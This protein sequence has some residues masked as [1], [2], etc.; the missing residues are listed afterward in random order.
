MI[1]RKRW[2]ACVF[3]G[4][5]VAGSVAYADVTLELRPSSDTVAN[6]GPVD[7]GVYAV[8]SGSGD[9]DV[10]RIRVVFTWDSDYLQLTGHQDGDYTW[11]Y[12]G[13]PTD[14]GPAGDEINLPQSGGVPD[15]DGDA[16]YFAFSDSGGDPPVA[17]TEGLHVTTL[18]FQS[19]DATPGT[20]VTIQSLI[21]STD[22]YI[23]TA[24]YGGD[25]IT[26]TIGS[27]STWSITC[28]TGNPVTSC[29]DGNLCTDDYC[30]SETS[31]THTPVSE[32][33]PCGDTG[34]GDCDDA[35]SCDASGN[36]LPNYWSPGTE[37]GNQ[38][39]SD[40]DHPNTCDVAGVCQPN[41]EPVGEACGNQD[42]SDCD[43]PDTCDGAGVC[44][45][46]YESL[47]GECG[48][49]DQTDCTDPDR[50]DGAGACD[51]V[52]ATNGFPCTDDENECTDDV[53]ETGEC[54]HPFLSVETPCGDDT[55]DA[56]TAPDW[57]D[58]I[59]TCLPRDLWD[60]YVW[61]D[62]YCLDVGGLA[63]CVEC[64]E[65][66][67]CDDENECTQDF[68]SGAHVCMNS[69]DGPQNG[70]PCTP[71]GVYC[72]GVDVCVDGDC[73]SPNIPPC[74][75][76]NPCTDAV[77]TEEPQDC[78]N[79]PNDS[80]DCDD[81][82]FC[83]NGSEYCQDGVC[84]SPG[85]PSCDDDNECTAD[86]CDDDPEIDDCVHENLPNMT[87]C[88]DG[89]PCTF[90]DYCL[91]GTCRSGSPPVGSGKVNL[92]WFPSAPTAILDEPFEI[93]LYARST[94]G[95][96]V[97]LVTIN[98]VLEWNPQKVEL[99]GINNNGPYA[100]FSTFFPCDSPQ[101]SL[102]T[103][104]FP[105][106]PDYEC[107]D[108]YPACCGGSCE[109]EY[110]DFP[111]NDGDALFSVY[112][113]L[114]APAQATP[115]P[116]LLITSF[117][118][119]ALET[120]PGTTLSLTLCKGDS[121]TVT[122]INGGNPPELVHGVLGSANI[123]VVT[124]VDDE[125]CDDGLF[126]NG[127]ERCVGETCVDA[128][129][130]ACDD[131][132]DCTEDYCDEGNDTCTN[133]PLDY[134]C[135][136][137][138]FCDGEEY[139]DAAHGCRNGVPPNCDDPDPCTEDYCD[140]DLDQC[141]NEEI[142]W[143][144]PCENDS[145]CED[146]IPCT[147]N[148]CDPFFEVCVY[149]RN[150]DFCID[151]GLYCNGEEICNPSDPDAD[152]DGC[153]HGPPPCAPED[154]DEINDTCPCAVPL[155]E[156]LGPRYIAITPQVDEGTRCAF[157]VT[158]CNGTIS[159]YVGDVTPWDVN[160]DMEIDSTLGFLIDNDLDAAFLTPAEWEGIVYVT[161]EDIVPE[162]Y[163]EVQ[164]DCGPGD[165]MPEAVP[166]TFQN[167][168]VT[169][170]STWMWGDTVPTG[171]VNIDDI[172]AVISGFQGGFMSL[173]GPTI[174]PN[175]DVMPC[176]PNQE[177]DIDDILGVIGGFQS[178]SYAESSLCGVPCAP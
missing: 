98:L 112:S 103:W 71:N 5:L 30:Q 12:A 53:C 46:N 40:C 23:A 147:T 55:D 94:T 170:E 145:Q 43:H 109:P 155:V 142:P 11:Y 176:L 65:A 86:W 25:F 24:P 150:H 132:H 21:G 161:G 77:C 121:P 82:E 22:T 153:A 163:Y 74:N 160:C 113:Q 164:A 6:G 105:D 118:F 36:C 10:G 157:L 72:D 97:D 178:K 171:E 48:N 62:I 20:S 73:L 33:L 133:T 89:E 91:S 141:V 108:P 85:P 39:E 172:L 125:D 126:C 130:E 129:T 117:R 52:H 177:I 3:A 81:G 37:C 168:Y 124:C 69:S 96:P 16:F 116:G 166:A 79:V 134:L 101:D 60:C 80:N 7:V 8:W 128:E 42:D 122:K 31:C 115:A 152:E 28:D 102:N 58:G 123:L 17:T 156:S 146:G 90:Y 173:L 99:L 76:E 63:T 75:D 93:G 87:G 2:L 51:P 158:Y 100:W 32:G 174:L 92:A 49:Q 114:G 19:L 14:P 137:D 26:I 34:S 154:C 138:L 70:E 13:F 167:D 140:E 120:T 67:H 66:I 38:D 169:Y 107:C 44:Q 165:P 88:E 35:D 139:C 159:K 15:N 135:D 18:E 111:D 47:G 106:G 95:G 148:T 149:P 83:L 64:L 127:E 54:V 1:T 78:Y 45:L 175:L 56:C 50:C 9:Q 61:P 162:Y 59:G 29:D 4:V 27:G 136:N 41:Y 131:G 110:P 68:C 104:Q 84:I 151:D 144:W 143:C 119:L 57:C